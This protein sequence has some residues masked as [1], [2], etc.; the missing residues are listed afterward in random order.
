MPSERIVFKVAFARWVSDPG[1][2]DL[3]G[4]Y[5]ES[6]RPRSRQPGWRPA[7]DTAVAERV[8]H[9]GGERRELDQLAFP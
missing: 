2:P 9:R 3:P 4:I 1:Q 7:R 5:R 6:R 8:G